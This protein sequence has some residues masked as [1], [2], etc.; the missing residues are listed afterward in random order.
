MT[1]IAA[2]LR[3][4]E[5]T[6]NLVLSLRGAACGDAAIRNS[7]PQNENIRSRGCGAG[8]FAAGKALSRVRGS[9]AA[10]KMKSFS[11]GIHFCPK[12]LLAERTVRAK[13]VRGAERSLLKSEPSAAGP[14]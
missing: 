11:G 5:G 9:Q 8:C 4:L 10:N 6:G 7:R 2:L 13:R 14:I 12:I 1:G 3:F